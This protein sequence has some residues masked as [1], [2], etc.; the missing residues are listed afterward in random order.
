MF[1]DE[2]P[3]A[4]NAPKGIV[5]HETS[6]VS[7]NA[8]EI[9]ERRNITIIYGRKWCTRQG[10]CIRSPPCRVRAKENEEE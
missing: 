9:Y 5:L 6:V 8:K 3:K 10:Y 7:C 4:L 1:H 2:Y